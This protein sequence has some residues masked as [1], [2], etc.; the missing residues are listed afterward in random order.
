MST[1]EIDGSRSDLC[2]TDNVTELDEGFYIYNLNSPMKKPNVKES[3]ASFGGSSILSLP[4]R[5]IRRVKSTPDLL[6]IPPSQ[7]SRKTSNDSAVGS[8]EESESS[9]KFSDEATNGKTLSR[10]T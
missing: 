9:D 6:Q 1:G 5:T 2:R 10:F 3:G 4:P 8:G 7:R